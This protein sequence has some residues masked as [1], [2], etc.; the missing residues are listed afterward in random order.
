MIILIFYCHDIIKHQ[1]AESY[2]SD[3]CV[4][5]EEHETGCSRMDGGL[6]QNLQRP[7]AHLKAGHMTVTAKSAHGALEA[8]RRFL[9]GEKNC[10]LGLTASRAGSCSRPRSATC[11]SLEAGRFTLHSN[12]TPTLLLRF[13]EKKSR[14]GRGTFN[15][16]RFTLRTS[17]R[18][19]SAVLPAATGGTGPQR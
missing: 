16:V 6:G 19:R 1:S 3:R 5:L 17:L 2:L 7:E 8:R 12:A 18:R 9:A 14:R 13:C 4:L 15:R 10:A 11:S